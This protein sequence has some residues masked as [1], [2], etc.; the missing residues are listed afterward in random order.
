MMERGWLAITPLVSGAG[1]TFASAFWAGGIA[2]AAAAS[3][4]RREPG[5]GRGAAGS[6]A[7]AAAWT[8][9]AG[10]A[11]ASEASA[12]SVLASDDELRSVMAA[13]VR[14]VAALSRFS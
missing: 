7:G 8:C 12:I 14:V 9:G 2:A 5:A 6:G 13:T 10:R 3:A 4:D 11:V 1:S